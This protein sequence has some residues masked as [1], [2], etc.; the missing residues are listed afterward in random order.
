MW[1]CGSILSHGF[2]NNHETKLLL[3]IIDNLSLMGKYLLRQT[4]SGILILFTNKIHHRSCI[5]SYDNGVRGINP[6]FS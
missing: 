1:R 5:K 6:F 4:T 2:D 3:F